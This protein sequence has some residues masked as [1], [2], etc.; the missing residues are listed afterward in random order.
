MDVYGV[1]Y[2]GL[3]SFSE[4]TT[5]TRWFLVYNV[6]YTLDGRRRGGPVKLAEARDKKQGHARRR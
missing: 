2:V 3:I 1:Q 5:G 4:R 6:P